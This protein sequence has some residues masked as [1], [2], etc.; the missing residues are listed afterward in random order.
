MFHLGLFENFD[1]PRILYANSGDPRLTNFGFKR[2]RIERSGF[3]K[4]AIGS[5]EIP[6]SSE[7]FALSQCFGCGLAR[8]F[9]GHTS[10]T[11]LNQ[12]AQ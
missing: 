11:G 3:A 4:F 8:G 9:N 6:S 2:R 10:A 1:R 12:L 5:I 7:L